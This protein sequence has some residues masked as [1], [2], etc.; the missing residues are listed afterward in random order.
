MPLPAKLRHDLLRTKPAVCIE[1]ALSI[2]EQG[3]IPFREMDILNN[4]QLKTRGLTQV[5][6]ARIRV[7]K[8]VL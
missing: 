3:I 7:V 8:P 2:E 6:K 4:H 5:L 1:R